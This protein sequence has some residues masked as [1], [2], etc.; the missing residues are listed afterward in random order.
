MDLKPAEYVVHLFGGV[1]PAA[2]ALD[3]SPSAVSR[4]RKHDG[5]V[6]TKA[7]KIILAYAKK[8]RLDINAHDLE[9]GRRLRRL[10]KA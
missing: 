5:E 10:P 1:R 6:P 3:Y 8:H 4:W 9:Y 2:R 7:R